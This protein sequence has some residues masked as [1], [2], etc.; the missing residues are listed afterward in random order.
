MD[1]KCVESDAIEWCIHYAIETIVYPSVNNIIY[2]VA[3]IVAMEHI[4]YLTLFT[5][6]LLYA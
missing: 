1:K 5:H 6:L 4:C 2:T 3:E